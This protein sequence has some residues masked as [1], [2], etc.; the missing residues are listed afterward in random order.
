MKFKSPKFLALFALGLALATRLPAQTT[1]TVLILHDSTGQYGW[2]GNL[3][4]RRRDAS[5]DSQ[6]AGAESCRLQNPGR[7]QIPIAFKI[8]SGQKTN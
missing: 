6:S 1:N 4:P 2:I 7:L 8:G 5:V 3:S